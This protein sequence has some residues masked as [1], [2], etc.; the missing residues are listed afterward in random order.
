MGIE[1]ILSPWVRMNLIVR[2]M[3]GYFKLP[4][5]PELEPHQ[6]MQ[7]SQDTLGFWM[8]VLT[9][10]RGYSQHILSPTDKMKAP[11]KESPYFPGVW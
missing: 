10:K 8:G 9:L 7:F 3:K 2:T 5:G 11:L 4:I 1:Q 6:Q